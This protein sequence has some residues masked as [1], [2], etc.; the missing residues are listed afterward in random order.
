MVKAKDLPVFKPVDQLTSP[1][2][3][4][5]YLTDIIEADHSPLLINA[6]CGLAIKYG[7]RLRHSGRT[8]ADLMRVCKAAGVKVI[9]REVA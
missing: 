5:V 8:C 2:M 7:V 6:I 1:E 3:V 4:A 9:I